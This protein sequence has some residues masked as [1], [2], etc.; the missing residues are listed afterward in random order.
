M[1]IRILS[2][3]IILTILVSLVVPVYAAGYS[4]GDVDGNGTITAADARLALRAS[5]GLE[6]L[7]VK[8]I[9]AADIDRKSGITASDAR[10]ILRASVGLENLSAQNKP[11]TEVSDKTIA[12]KYIEVFKKSAKQNG[13]TTKSI[14]EKLSKSDIVDMATLVQDMSPGY[15]AGFDAEIAGFKKCTAF[16]PMI[17]TIPF[18]SYVFEIAPYTDA[19]SF[20]KY[21]KENANLRWNICTTAD[22]M[23]VVKEGK[24][25]FFIMSPLYINSNN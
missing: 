19:D 16:V 3:F 8:Q 11:G 23:C 25:I 17:G 18:V 1:K 5:V 2:I 10:L 7:S 4:I 12:E 14:A 20:I 21:L 22:E 24:F 9:I 6:K 13:A 15:F